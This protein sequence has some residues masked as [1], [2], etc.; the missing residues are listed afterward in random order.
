MLE[1]VSNE[2]FLAPSAGQ[3]DRLAESC[4]TESPMMTMIS[5]GRTST[6]P[7]LTRPRSPVC[8][9]FLL[10]S[11][12]CLCAQLL[13]M[14]ALPITTAARPWQPVAGQGGRAS[15]L[16][17]PTGWQ[18]LRWQPTQDWAAGAADALLELH[19]RALHYLDQYV[20]F[21]M[22]C[23]CSW[24]YLNDGLW[25]CQVWSFT[26][27]NLELPW[28]EWSCI[29]LLHCLPTSCAFIHVENAT[30]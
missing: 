3:P 18:T 25:D 17:R 9:L 8:K 13:L 26:R 15:W 2:E 30:P 29:L 1:V 28:A 6:G 19:S 11:L 22:R 4:V 14:L 10:G 23:Y 27:S 20:H 24:I 5:H 16:G 7:R 21:K 12:P